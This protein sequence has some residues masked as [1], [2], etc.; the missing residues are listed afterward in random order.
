[1]RAAK[2]NQTKNNN[3]KNNTA[4]I[5]STD[6]T[7]PISKPKLERESGLLI[8]IY[9]Q[10]I[11]NKRN[12][13]K[14][15]PQPIAKVLNDTFVPCF[16]KIC[17]LGWEGEGVDEEGEE[18][19]TD[20]RAGVLLADRVSILTEEMGWATEGFS[21]CEDVGTGGGVGGGDGVVDDCILGLKNGSIDELFSDIRKYK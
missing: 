1:M 16:A 19:E 2:P 7:V 9:N 8:A 20:Q 18:G 14:K 4:N 13:Q 10:T 15:I 3:Q 5:K 12:N 11:T 17:W 6:F 21:F